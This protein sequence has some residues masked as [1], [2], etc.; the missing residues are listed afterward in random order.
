MAFGRQMQNS[1]RAVRFK[2]LAEDFSIANVAVNETICR[3]VC[4]RG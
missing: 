1:V 3:L 4:N 2:G